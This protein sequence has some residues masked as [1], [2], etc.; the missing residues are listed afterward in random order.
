VAK[1]AFTGS[2]PTG[3]AVGKAAM[4]ANLTRAT[5]ELGGKNAAALLA[6][7]DVDGAVAGIVQTAYVHQGQVCASPERLY[8]H[9]SRVDEFTGKLAARWGN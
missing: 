5:L 9:R 1:V 4:A 2:V 7:V 8:V 3:I 6:D